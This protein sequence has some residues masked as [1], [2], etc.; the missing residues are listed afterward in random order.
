MT[1]SSIP[2]FVAMA[3]LTTAAQPYE[4]GAV[5]S[6]SGVD[7]EKL[8]KRRGVR[9]VVLAF[10]DTSA[11]SRSQ[12]DEWSALQRDYRAQGLHIVSITGLHPSFDRDEFRYITCEH[13]GWDADQFS[14]DEIGFVSAGLG[15]KERPTAFLW[16]WPGRLL[17]QQGDPRTVR[18]AIQSDL[19]RRPDVDKST[20]FAGVQMPTYDYSN[21]REKARQQS[22]ANLAKVTEPG[23]EPLIAYA[24][25]WLGTP[26]QMYGD[27]EHGIDDYNLVYD[28]YKKVYGIEVGRT[29]RD[30]VGTNPEV[31]VDLADVQATLRPGDL[32][33]WVVHAGKIPRRVGVYL[34]NGMYLRVYQVRGVTVDPLP[35]YTWETYWLVGRRP[36]AHAPN[37]ERAPMPAPA[38]SNDEEDEW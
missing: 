38:A 35:N 8:L 19:G 26:Y 14:C 12:N 34:G 7:V 5:R 23:S 3:V 27:S 24:K 2:L 33:G 15:V 37:Y 10:Q 6:K 13:P 17:V 16:T 30:Q 9:Y 32:I 29:R 22:L 31:P 4:G 1:T 20:R 28:L 18:A 11:K 21:P 25:K 36:L